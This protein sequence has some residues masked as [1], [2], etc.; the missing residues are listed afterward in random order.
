MDVAFAGEPRGFPQFENGLHAF[1]E[2]VMKSK[3]N[4]LRNPRSA[5][6][7][8]TLLLVL[9]AWNAL[10]LFRLHEGSIPYDP[11]HRLWYPERKIYGYYD[12]ER[13]LRHILFGAPEAP[14]R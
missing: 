2:R 4:S 14:P 7:L 1:E 6:L 8:A 13:R 9:G 5:L 12:Y 11:E 10:S 3:K